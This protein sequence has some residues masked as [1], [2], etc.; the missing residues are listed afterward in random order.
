MADIEQTTVTAGAAANGL[1]N[2]LKWAVVVLMVVFA[3]VGNLH[4]AGSPLAIR[5]AALI[6]VGVVALFLAKTTSQGGMA[7]EFIKESRLEMR[8]VVW[9]TRQETIQTTG[10]VIAVVAIMSLILWGVDSI[11]AL[12]ISNIIM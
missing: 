5:A 8:K 11:F 2:K 10:L 1:T 9:P 3:V 4:F 12:I 6:V 7:W